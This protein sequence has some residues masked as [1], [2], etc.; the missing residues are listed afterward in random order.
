[1]GKNY[2]IGICGFGFVG[3]ALYNNIKDKKS[4]Q[5]F[6][7]AFEE[8]SDQKVLLDTDVVFICVGTPYMD[9]FV[10]DA[11]NL[12]LEYLSKYCYE[13]LVVIKS[14]IHPQYI[15]K[16]Y[17][18]NLNLLSN[19][20]FLNEHNALDDFKNQTLNIIG[21][22]IDLAHKLQDI[23]NTC[24]DLNCEYKLMSFDEALTFK[25]IRNIKIAYEVMFWEMVNE[26]AGNYRKYKKTLDK[27]PIDIKSICL[28]GK[29]GYGGHCLPKDIKSYPKT[30]LTDFLTKYNESIRK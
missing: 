28:D 20:E 22:R 23:Y 10:G 8:Y 1:M 24:F 7:P 12:N 17:T 26:T 2:N 21:G 13:G 30:A 18:Y 14:T 19:P 27:L 16:K 3:T 4:I 6:D 5:I 29:R 9:K 11:V 15:D 25:Y